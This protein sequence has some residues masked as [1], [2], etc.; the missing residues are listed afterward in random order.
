[1]TS[2]GRDP[3][4]VFV[5]GLKLVGEAYKLIWQEA[6]QDA[7]HDAAKLAAELREATA[8]RRAAQAA[9]QKDKQAKT[10]SLAF[11]L[12]VGVA[13]RGVDALESLAT[14]VHAIREKYTGSSS[15]GT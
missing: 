2:N 11:D 5:Q 4:D 13:S 6:K 8:M 14:D 7:K 12:A 1:M 9:K 3:G 10:P 15:T